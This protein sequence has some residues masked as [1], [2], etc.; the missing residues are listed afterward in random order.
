MNTKQIL[1]FPLLLASLLTAES[2]ED[3]AKKDYRKSARNTEVSAMARISTNR[4]A[5]GV[6]YNYY[7]HKEIGHRM[8]KINPF[9][10]A[11][12]NATVSTTTP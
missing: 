11:F 1:I 6:K 12:H 8:N 7:Y 2:F 10:I 9:G 4:Y 3:T 5:K